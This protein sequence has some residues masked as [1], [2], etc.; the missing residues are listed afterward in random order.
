[1]KNNV[2]EVKKL[3]KIYHEKNNETLALDDISFNI[4]DKEYISI[5]GPSGCGKST[6][7][8][9]V[10]NIVTKS[11][12]DIIFKNNNP[13][14][15]YMLQQDALLEWKTVLENCLLGLEITKKLNKTSKENVLSLLKKYGLKDFI[16]S[17]P[18][19]LSGGM[20]QRVALIR[21]LAINPDILL[22]DEPFSS[23]DYQTRLNLSNDLYNIIKNE[24]K[25]AIMVTHDIAEAI[26]MSDRIILLSKRPAIIKNIYN[27]ELE[28]KSNPIENRKDKNFVKYYEMIWKE[29]DN[30]V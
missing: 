25:T 29:L 23:L 18:N 21:T 16:N 28:N 7:L 19:S 24:H 26:S 13:K 11:N 4:K 30:H 22:L 14:I 1:M 8:G 9:I 5:V 17:Y 3:K 12:G 10:A 15:G 2:L 6:I 20:R 27:I